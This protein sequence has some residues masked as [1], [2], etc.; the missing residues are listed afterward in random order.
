MSNKSYGLVKERKEKEWL[1]KLGFTANR[2]RGSF[3]GFDLVACNKEYFL[4][5]SIKATKRDKYSFKKEIEEIKNFDNAPSGTH[6][7]LILYHKGQRKVLF[8]KVL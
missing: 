4:L 2:N 1:E 3:G 6:C 8:E 5:E 7:K